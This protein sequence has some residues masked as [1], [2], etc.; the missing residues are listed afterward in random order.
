MSIKLSHRYI[1]WLFCCCYICKKKTLKHK[2]KLYTERIIPITRT[3]Y[4]P[5]LDW[6]CATAMQAYSQ[7]YMQ[8]S[9]YMYRFIFCNVSLHLIPCCKRPNLWRWM[10]NWKINTK[11]KKN[12]IFKVKRTALHQSICINLYANWHHIVLLCGNIY[13]FFSD[14]ILCCGIA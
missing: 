12:V 11:K 2:W 6:L 3:L 4:I 13:F 9:R 7:F 14:I 5:I 8:R 10:K 1:H